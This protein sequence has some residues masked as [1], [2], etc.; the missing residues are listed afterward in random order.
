LRDVSVKRIEHVDEMIQAF[1]LIDEEG[2]KG[3]SNFHFPVP[4]ADCTKPFIAKTRLQGN[5]IYEMLGLSAPG[6]TRA[7]VVA[8]QF[9]LARTPHVTGSMAMITCNFAA[10]RMEASQL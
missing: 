7:C 8:R 1:D 5:E 6:G 3:E 2:E 9:K 4:S 10:V